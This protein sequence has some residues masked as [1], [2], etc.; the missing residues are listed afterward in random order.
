VLRALRPRRG[1]RAAAA[2]VPP[3]QGAGAAARRLLLIAVAAL[4]PP[5]AADNPADSPARA[6]LKPKADESLLIDIARGG[7]R[8]VVVGERGHVL[9][10]T[11]AV[12][13][14]QAPVPTRVMLT[15]VALDGRGRG[16]AVG[17]EATI[18]RTRD[19]GETWERVYH[20]PAADA[21]LLDVVIVDRRRIVAVGAYG[22]YLESRDAGASWTARTLEPRDLTAD[23][24]QQA[25]AD[26]G[27][28]YDVHLNDIAV[29][30]GGRWYIAAEA[31]TVY[32]S[33]DAGASWLRLPSPYE[34]SFYGVLPLRRERVLL[35]G[36][37]GRL[38]VSGDA[39][40]RWRRIETGTR[41]ALFA[42]RRL[43]DGGAL[44][45]GRAGVVLAGGIDQGAFQ[46]ARLPNRPSLADAHVL[47]DGTLLSAGENGIRRWPPQAWREP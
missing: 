33:D 19:H 36:L 44:I 37:Q 42:G 17:H 20:D 27:F 22:L 2:G 6:W 40:A 21:P 13:W 16:I 38:F 28:F 47:D 25:G 1:A 9:Y 4:C 7:G 29:A 23:D 39:G 24:A 31:G 45:I 30:A 32:R 5:A 3:G 35:F 11:D 41:A 10:S 34:G 26:D 8:W 15:A 18:I 43:P 14:T 12:S 46:H